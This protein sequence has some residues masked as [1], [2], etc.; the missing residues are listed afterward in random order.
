MLIYLL[1]LYLLWH[2]PVHALGVA[3][4]VSEGAVPTDRVARE[5]LVRVRVWVRVW[6]W[7]RARARARVR[8]KVRPRVRPRVRLRVG[9]RLRLRLRAYHALDAH[10]LAPRLQL[11]A[12]EVLR[13]AAP[14]LGV[15][16]DLVRRP[17]RQAAPL[18][19]R[20]GAAGAGGRPTTD[21]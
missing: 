6:V 17:A 4:S 8:P 3:L 16:G 15:V 2:A 12:E 20:R 7:A 5:H 9:L 13:S 14:L 18:P 1:W 19:G 21:D 11:V 10:G